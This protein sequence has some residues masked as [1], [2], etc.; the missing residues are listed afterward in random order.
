MAFT[1]VGCNHDKEDPIVL[2]CGDLDSPHAD[3]VI[4][5]ERPGNIL[6]LKVCAICAKPDKHNGAHTCAHGHSW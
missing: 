1:F 3:C 4:C 2:K 5:S 6:L